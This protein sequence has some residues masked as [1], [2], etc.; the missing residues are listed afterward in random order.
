MPSLDGLRGADLDR[1]YLRGRQKLGRN[2]ED[3]PP[4]AHGRLDDVGEDLLELGLE[5]GLLLHEPRGQNVED[6]PV[7]RQ[8]RPCLAVGVLNESARLDVDRADHSVRM[9]FSAAAHSP[10]E[11]VGVF[12]GEADDPDLG[13][14]AVLGD[15]ASRYAR[16]FLD[17]VRRAGGRIVEDDLLGDAPA[18]GVGQLIEQVVAGDGVAVLG[19]QDHRV[20]EG[21][22]ARQDRHLGHRIGVVQSRRRQRVARLVVGGQQLVLIVH[23]PRAPLRTGHDAVDGLIDVGHA[24]RPAPEPGGQQSRLVED[25]LQVSSRVSGRAPGHHGQVDVGRERL[26][27]GVDLEDGLAPP[28]VGGVHGDLAVE[29]AGAQQSRVEHVGPVRRRDEDDVGV[30]VEAVEL[31]E[32]LVEGLLAFVVAAADSHAAAAAHG[33]DLVDEDYGRRI[34]LGLVEQVANAR[35]AHAHEHF[36]ELGGRDRIE[37]HPGLARHRPGQEGLARSGRPVKE[38]SSGDLRP[39]R[40]KA[41]GR[42]EKL[43]DLPQLGD[44]LV[45][46]GDVVEGDVGL[47]RVELLAVLDPAEG[48]HPRLHARQKDHEGH[49]DDEH[50]NGHRQDRGPDRGL[51]H[52]RV[53]SELRLRLFGQPRDLLGLR[54]DV[55]ELDALADVVALPLLVGRLRRL[56]EP[57]TDLLRPLG[58][59]HPLDLLAFEKRDSLGSFDG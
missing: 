51:G 44:G 19:G 20:A 4:F 14:H 26:A 25:V 35:G 3:M 58:D 36:D 48:P 28:E 49:D 10:L 31:D 12:G 38:D 27:L 22:P 32:E 18:H 1:R 17:V 15:H 42:G 57:Q 56:R 34:F 2:L 29:S 47:V 30:R 50:R 6:S 46:P 54:L 39:E 13:A 21:A 8:N 33:V 7:L 40:V 53:V 55:G 59:L 52:D 37:G 5:H 41:F 9:D 45:L 11:G 24:D 23:R 43:G 16:G